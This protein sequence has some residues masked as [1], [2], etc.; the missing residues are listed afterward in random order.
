MRA[1][2]NYRTDE[3]TLNRRFRDMIRSGGEPGSMIMDFACLDET[4][5]INAPPMD[6]MSVSPATAPLDAL[7]VLATAVAVDVAGPDDAS[8]PREK[9]HGGRLASATAASVALA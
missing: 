7:D 4:D 2:I 5:P 3:L 9:A 6:L 8:S 1:S